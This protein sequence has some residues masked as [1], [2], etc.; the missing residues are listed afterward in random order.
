MA[1]RK[2][3]D[4]LP[5]DWPDYAAIPTRAEWLVA[6]EEERIAERAFE[7]MKTKRT[8]EPT[9]ESIA[10][11]EAH[12]AEAHVRATET[13][14]RQVESKELLTATNFCD[15]L[16]VDADWL[17]AALDECRVFAITGPGGRS[18]FPAFYADPTIKR[19][20][21]ERVTRTLALLHPRSQFLFYT[22]VR[23]SLGETPLD[24]LRAGRLEDVMTAAL[25]ATADAPPRVPSIVETLTGE[26][27]PPIA[28]PRHDPGQSFADVLKGAK[29]H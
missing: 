14:R 16:E 15:V 2:L 19:E 13:V 18:Y 28:A 23:T 12:L 11:G 25:G 27:W 20:H 26:S 10:A 6:Q 17:D 29:P 21:I 7:Q 5:P 24:A 1:N 8:Q 4:Y 22:T 3:P 9:P